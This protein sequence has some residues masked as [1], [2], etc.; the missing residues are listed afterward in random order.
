MPL[1]NYSLTIVLSGYILYLLRYLKATSFIA[2][3]YTMVC[4][5]VL[6]ILQL[7]YPLTA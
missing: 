1:N 3:T 6:H 7:L 5:Y 4:H 2:R